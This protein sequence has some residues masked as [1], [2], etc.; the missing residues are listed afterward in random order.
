MADPRAENPASDGDPLGLAG[1]TVVIG[2]AGTAGMSAARYLVT[3]DVRILLADDRFAAGDAGAA[4]R[5]SAVAAVPGVADLIAQGAAAVAI[6]DLLVDPSWTAD[7]AVVIVSPGFAPTHDLVAQAAAGG[8]PVWGEVEL[9]WRVDAAGLLG[10]PRTWLVVTGTNGK[11]TTTSMLA[12]IVE[13]SGR[14]GAACGN[15][16]LPVLDAMRATP[17]VD[18]LCA[19]LSSFQLHW[20]PSVAPAAGVVL[21]VADDHLD[22]H[23]TFDA[24]ALAKAGALRGD[25]AVVGLDDAVASGLPGAG[26]RV[27]FTLNPPQDGQLGVE[28][29]Q[30]VDRAFG[31]GRLLSADAVHP[32]GPSGVADALAA[33]ALALSIGVE[34][35]AV[36][37]ALTDFRPAAH[38]GEVVATRDG[39][40]FVDDSK[41]TNPH[42]AQAAV[43]AYDRVVLIAGGRLKGAS[44]D[45]MLTAVGDRLAGVVAIGR[46]REL[47]VEAITRHA[48]EVP[49]VTVFTGDD[50]TVNVHRQGQTAPVLSSIPNS[51]TRASGSDTAVAV[52]DRAVAEAW[53]LATASDPKPDAVLLAPAAASLDMFAGYGRRGD[54]FAHAA[55]DIAGTSAA[56]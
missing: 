46:D 33:A 44:M 50:G 19:E 15:I 52:M 47:V 34:R 54:A 18:V 21:N 17:R 4:D 29:G 1:K 23:G 26:R 40:R 9:A 3:R 39:I 36:E 48:P 30:L 56:R 6:S 24:Y 13:R 28:D 38:R 8:V 7:T 55:Q 10:E 35:D 2:G 11:T 12:D 31:A 37:T 27:G 32:A 42:A 43:A 25:I 14:A 22:W 16:G 51:S 41:A 5:E 20:A 45:G 53:E 49:T